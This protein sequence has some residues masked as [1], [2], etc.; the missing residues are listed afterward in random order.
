MVSVREF[1]AIAKHTTVALFS[2]Q[3][4]ITDMSD[5][6][7]EKPSLEHLWKKNGVWRPS[8]FLRSFLIQA[9]RR[10]PQP[11]SADE[12]PWPN[13][14]SGVAQNLT[15]LFPGH[16]L[17]MS[18]ILCSVLGD[19]DSL[20][21]LSQA[22]ELTIVD[23]A[24]G[25]GMAS[26]ATVDFLLQVL[27]ARLL[28]RN[29]PLYISFL[30]NDL[31]SACL[32][33][34]IENVKL[35]SKLLASERQP[36]RV[37]HVETFEG[38]LTG[39]LPFLDHERTTFDLLCFANA[40]DLVL[41]HGERVLEDD[42]TSSDPIARARPCDRPA[43]LADF[44]QQLGSHANPYFSRALF[45]QEWRYSPLMPIALPSRNLKVI[46]T[47]V[48]QEVLRPDVPDETMSV[49]FCYCGCRYAFATDRFPPKQELQSLPALEDAPSYF[50]EQIE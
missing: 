17:K 7:S 37:G 36:L 9:K 2:I 42:P 43:I 14:D 41:I 34:A 3:E 47:R 23:L 8:D 11:A 46:R 45:L 12:A 30:L 18:H 28:N 25:P 20:H 10:Y 35:V 48:I 29:A 32:E 39:I 13:D 24:S 40:F 31:K 1:T 4:E 44:F 16:S 5:T 26:I 50:M 38:S 27:K 15:Y 33:A 49:R 6:K 19:H 21:Y 22:R